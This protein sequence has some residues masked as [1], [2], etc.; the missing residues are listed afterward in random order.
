VVNSLSTVAPTVSDGGHLW[1]MVIFNHT[2]N[3]T[4]FY[5]STDPKETD[6]ADV[7][8]SLLG[9]AD[10]AHSTGGI[11]DGTALFTVGGREDDGSSNPL[12]G[13]INKAIL[14]SGTD[15]TATPAV[16]MNAADA[17]MGNGLDSDTFVS[18]ET[19]ETY[20]MNG[21]THAN[22]S[23]AAGLTF[24][25]GAGLETSAGGVTIAHPMHI[26]MV[27]QAYDLDSTT[28]LFLSAESDLNNAV[29]IYINSADNA[30][31]VGAGLTV[32][33]ADGDTDLHLFSVAHNGDA[34]SYGQVSGT[35]PVVADI[36]AENMDALTVGSNAG[37]SNYAKGS[38]Y[39][40]YIFK[41]RV[42]PP[43]TIERLERFLTP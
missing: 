13:L 3:T 6:Y 29:Q 25:G 34:S 42:L 12:G 38:M 8:W 32:K 39:A 33:L 30:F 20:T 17:G 28:Q 24:L 23:G 26:F 7:S 10:V 21:N 15:P 14:I 18:S 43:P 2:A 41:Q 4:N 35:A 40:L 5:T 11:Y 31:G 19:G 22:N 16:S 1:M 27:A 9:N 36:G 37:T